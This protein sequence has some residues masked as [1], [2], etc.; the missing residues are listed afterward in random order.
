MLLRL[1][2]QLIRRPEN[3]T[4]SPSYRSSY[5]SPG[6]PGHRSANSS[7]RAGSSYSTAF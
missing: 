1:L 5:S 7:P 6:R 2:R 4:Y 3:V